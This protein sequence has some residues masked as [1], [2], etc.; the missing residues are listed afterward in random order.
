[1]LTV[2]A[3]SAVLAACG[4]GDA[5]TEAPGYAAGA[6]LAP[7]DIAPKSTALT[8]SGAV[9]TAPTSPAALEGAA[10]D[11][12]EMAL[13]STDTADLAQAQSE[14]SAGATADARPAQP[15]AAPT[16][17]ASSVIVPSEPV[18][19]EP[20]APTMHM[21]AVS[22]AQ[23]T[24]TNSVSS[25]V[26]T[27]GLF[28]PL[29]VAVEDWANARQLAANDSGWK[30]W[31]TSRRDLLSRWFG[32]TRD[33]A[34]LVAGYPNDFVNPLTGAAVSWTM[35]IAEP[36]N[37][38]TAAEIRYKAAWAAI[39]RQYNITRTLDAARLYQLQGDTTLAEVAAKQLDLYA[40]N[41]AKW[42]LRTSIGNARMMAQ[43][44][45]EAVSVLELLEAAKALAPYAAA[46][47][48][49]KWRDSL[50]RP[51]AANVQTYT[52]GPL[53][54]INLW[55]AAAVTAVGL[56]ANDA[57]LVTAGTTGPQGTNA[58]L[59]SGLNA[60]G[61]WFEGSFSYNNYVILAL[62]RMFDV[63]SQYGR[64]DLVQR[65]APQVQ[66]LLALPVL[67]NFD[68]GSLPAPSD[69]RSAVA[70]VD[71]GT[72]LAM[73]RHVPTSFGVMAATTSRTWAT[74][75]DVPRASAL[76]LALPTAVSLNAEAS[77]MAQLRMGAWQ[78]YVHYG[79]STVNHAQ[80]EALTYELVHGTTSI[81]RDAG[82]AASYSLPQHTEY[83]SKGVG[84]NVA[85][86]DGL[87]Q[88]QWAP[89]VVR[90]FDA[91]NGTLDA[92]QPSY[93]SD[94]N[95][96]RSYKLSSSGFSETTR[97]TL[98]TTQATPRRLGVMFNTACQIA[99]TD[100][101]AGTAAA[102]T[103]PTGSAGFKFWT[104]ITKRSAQASWTAKLTCAGKAYELAINGPAAHTVYSATAPNTPLPATRN[105]LYVEAP[106]KDV[107]FTTSIRALP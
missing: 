95:V 2:I 79:Q 26:S 12:V 54:N 24:T 21:S 18:P 76:P 88:Q 98:P 63:A 67:F 36:A 69:T 7:A 5:A 61:L 86:I 66:R 96:Q 75:L 29:H 30:T 104:A 11:T 4:G 93:R 53:N 70:P 102:A 37:G 39:N 78:L 55:C 101:R 22:A 40:D 83:F 68:D 65:Y 19:A 94:A 31:T 45:D 38:T 43:S 3:V 44:L 89:G 25:L 82:T 77:R 35:D 8:A 72:H 58:V 15:S 84:N 28:L 91:V 64:G 1:M 52:Y 50:F 107:S 33:R 90:S 59:A 97:I 105:A 99:I 34:D 73:Y 23:A 32:R 47:R 71:R 85:L 81:T 74:L 92:A 6:A 13:V 42:P 100:P 60:D 10:A 56:Y 80:E 41:Y 17:E 9:D 57:A 87:G 16:A 20:S 103:A 49:A 48:Q 46:A 14:L 51:I 27:L 106:G 62:A